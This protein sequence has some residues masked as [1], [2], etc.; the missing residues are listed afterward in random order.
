MAWGGIGAGRWVGRNLF[1]NSSVLTDNDTLY[2]FCNKK[3]VYEA[4]S[5]DSIGQ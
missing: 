1:L 5:I 2:F 4:E 3:N